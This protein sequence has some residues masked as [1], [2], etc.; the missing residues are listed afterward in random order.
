VGALHRETLLNDIGTQ[1]L[2]H[3]PAVD[4]PHD[5]CFRLVGH[6]ML[7]GRWRLTDI[8]VAL[9]RIPPV[10]VSLTGGEYPPA[11]RPLLDQGAFIL[12]KDPLHLEQHPSLRTRAKG[13]LRK[14][15]FIEHVVPTGR[16]DCNRNM[17]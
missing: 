8:R 7:W 9:G 13:L 1:R 2:R 4:L 12:R 5:L 15:N 6:E 11:A 14:D 3:A 17:G 16:F 10:D